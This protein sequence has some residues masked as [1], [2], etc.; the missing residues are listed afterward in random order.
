MGNASNANSANS[1]DNA[2]IADS[3]QNLALR[4]AEVL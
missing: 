1:A 3:G 2:V 4:L